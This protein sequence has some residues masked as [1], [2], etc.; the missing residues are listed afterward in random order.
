[1]TS[2]LQLKKSNCKNCY[3]CIRECP[4]KAIKFSE[5]Q[6]NIINDECIY[7]GSCFVTCPQNA[8]KI[9]NDIDIL[10]GLL[11]SEKPV[12]LSVAP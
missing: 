11:S 10:K 3:K 9:R 5:H 6:A 4:V 8:K 1:M 2:V 7:C 12:Y